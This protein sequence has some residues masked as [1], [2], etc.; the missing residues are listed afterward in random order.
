VSKDGL[1]ESLMTTKN[2]DDKA[3]DFM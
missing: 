3:F 1:S 2:S